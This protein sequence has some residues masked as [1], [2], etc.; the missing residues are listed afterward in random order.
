M[1]NM[2]LN[3]DY[4]KMYKGWA[5]L[6]TLLLAMFIS[7]KKGYDINC[8]WKEKA[9]YPIVL[10]E[11]TYWVIQ[12]SLFNGD[13]TV[14][15]YTSLFKTVYLCS[16][17]FIVFRYELYKYALVGAASVLLGGWCNDLAI[18]ANGGK[19]PAFPHL[20][21]L[22]GYVTP[23]AF[24]VADQLHILGSDLT[25]MK[26][27]TD[28]FDIGYSILSLGDIFIRILPFVVVYQGIKHAYQEKMM[29]THME[30][31]N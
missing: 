10:C 16:T 6:E 19:M 4:S 20:S 17:L 12:V 28:I 15:N 13:Y 31:I 21:Y 3:L 18:A 25:R 22:T 2:S 30:E 7:Y 26:W 11:A 14:L 29:T 5:M 8:I 23:E 1:T 24:G 27:L 9:F